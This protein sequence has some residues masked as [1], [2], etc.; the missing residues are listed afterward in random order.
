MNKFFDNSLDYIKI[1]KSS[2]S[3]IRINL[4]KSEI[5]EDTDIVDEGK[6]IDQKDNDDIITSIGGNL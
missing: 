4:D 3:P 2:K 1:I 5:I 6:D